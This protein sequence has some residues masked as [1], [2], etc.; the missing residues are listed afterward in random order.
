MRKQK[1][2]MIVI[3]KTLWITKNS[4]PVRFV[5]EFGMYMYE[6]YDLYGNDPMYRFGFCLA[7]VYTPKGKV[8]KY[9]FG[10]NYFGLIL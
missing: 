10:K 2:Y 5:F 4:I 8:D 3:D 7:I 1:D 9:R 6:C